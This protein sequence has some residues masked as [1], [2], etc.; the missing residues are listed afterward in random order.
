[1][2]NKYDTKINFFYCHH[3]YMLGYTYEN[4]KQFNHEDLCAKLKRNKGRFIL[5]YD[6][7][8]KCSSYTRALISSKSHALRALIARKPRR[9][10]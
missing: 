8:L 4:S 3:P 1:V 2:I 10:Q 5:S 7:N 9:V 6:D